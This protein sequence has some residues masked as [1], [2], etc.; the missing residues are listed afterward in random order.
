V[1]L[2]IKCTNLYW[3]QWV[4]D[5]CKEIENYS[6]ARLYIDDQIGVFPLNEKGEVYLFDSPEMT[7]WAIAF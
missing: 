6:G 1:A 5:L 4:V 7:N 2:K 3:V